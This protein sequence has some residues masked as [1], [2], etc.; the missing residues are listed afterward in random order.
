[1]FHIHVAGYAFSGAN[2]KRN[3]DLTFSGYRTVPSNGGPLSRTDID[4]KLDS[5][6]DEHMYFASNGKLNLRFKVANMYYLTFKVDSMHVGNGYVLMPGEIA[7][8]E[9]DA[10]LR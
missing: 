1:M 5:C 6:T 4:D 7:V 8:F 9:T 3:I 10:A 2:G